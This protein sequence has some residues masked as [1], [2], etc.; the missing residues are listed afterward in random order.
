MSVNELHL[1]NN[2]VLALGGTFMAVLLILP[3]IQNYLAMRK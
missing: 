2:F 3:S 1:M